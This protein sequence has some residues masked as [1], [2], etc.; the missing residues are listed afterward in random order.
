MNGAAGKMNMEKSLYRI[1]EKLSLHH[2]ETTVYPILPK[3]GLTS[4]K[5]LAHMEEPYDMVICGGGDGTLNHVINGLMMLDP[6]KRPILGYLP[7]GS[8]N[9][10]AKSVHIPEDIM[11]ATD[12]LFR[13]KQFSYDIGCFND[14]YFNYIA[15]FGAFSKISYSTDQSFKNA[16]GHAA[17]ILNGLVTLQE[18]IAYKCHMQIEADGEKMEDDYVFGAVYSATSVGGFRVGYVPDVELDDGRF[19]LLLIKAPENFGDLN[20]I[21]TAIVNRDLRSPYLS[22][23]QVKELKLHA[24]ENASWTLDGEYGGE[25]RDAEI[26]IYRKAITIMVE[27]EPEVS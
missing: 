2:Y 15:A 5:I 24:E 3:K 25:Y 10:F 27:D 1:I 12:V 20:K 23:M 17:Y 21:L 8:T 9:D 13:G 11:K 6:S 19:E 7:S 18:N 14:R 26:R 22:V 16:L 4:E